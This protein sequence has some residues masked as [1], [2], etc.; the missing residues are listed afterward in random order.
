MDISFRE[1]YIVFVNPNQGHRTAGCLRVLRRFP[2]SFF[3]TLYFLFD[4]G[5]YIKSVPWLPLIFKPLCSLIT[6]SIFHNKLLPLFSIKNRKKFPAVDTAIKS[7]KRHRYTHPAS[8]NFF[9]EFHSSWSDVNTGHISSAPLILIW[10]QLV[11]IPF[12]WLLILKL[13]G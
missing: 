1:N 5:W 2:S 6:V 4:K 7:L 10:V 11:A 12:L 8:G 3:L 9:V 13:F